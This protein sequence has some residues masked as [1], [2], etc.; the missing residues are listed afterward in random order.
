[1]ETETTEL[2]LVSRPGLVSNSLLSYCRSLAAH[3]FRSEIMEPEDFLQRADQVSA[4][5]LIVIEDDNPA[6]VDQILQTIEPLQRRSI[7]IVRD[8][9]R[10]CELRLKTNLPVLVWGL[11]DQSLAKFLF[12]K[13]PAVKPSSGGR[14]ADI[15]L[16]T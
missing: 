10:Q 12:E 6:E 1:M 8:I 15:P 11:I 14:S 16:F 2:V 9:H 4:D 7:V 3:N 5:I 13:V